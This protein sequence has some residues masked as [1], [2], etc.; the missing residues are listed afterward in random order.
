MFMPRLFRRRNRRPAAPAPRRTIL[1]FERLE[2][3]DVPSITISPATLPAPKAGVK[4]LQSL[5]ATGGTAPYTFSV[6]AGSLPAGIALTNGTLHGYPRAAGTFSFTIQA[7]DST[8]PTHQIGTQPYTFTVSGPTLSLSPATLPTVFAGKQYNQ[9]IIASGG[10]APYHFSITSGSLPTGLGLNQNSGLLSGKTGATGNYTFTVK[11]TDSTTGTGSPFSTSKTYTL[12]VIA[13]PGN[14]L[15]MPELGAAPG[16]PPLPSTLS[17]EVFDVL[18][19]PINGTVTLR[20]VP[21]V[22]EGGR[23]SF[24]SGPT[25][26]A[27]TT[28][29]VATFTGLAVTGRGLFE[30]R[31]TD[32]SAGSR[33]TASALSEEFEA[34]LDGRHSPGQ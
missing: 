1:S 8:S 30:L 6:S 33:V 10:S 28:N 4:Y 17:V 22:T 2:A 7:T 18:G 34:G 16:I 32:S 25:V 3:R 13:V 20:I 19:N 27:T 5:S 11:V 15:F 26:Q 12:R 24:T 31:A 23:L 29:G 9:N 14:V 21:I